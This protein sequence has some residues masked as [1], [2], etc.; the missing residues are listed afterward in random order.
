[1]FQSDLDLNAL[2]LRIAQKWQEL[3]GEPLIPG[4]LEMVYREVLVLIASWSKIDTERAIALAFDKYLKEIYLL[5]YGAGNRDAAIALAKAFTDVADVNIPPTTNPMA[6]QV[7]LLAKVGTPTAGQIAALQTYLNSPK[8][9]NTCDT[10][11]VAAAS[12]LLWNFNAIISVMGDPIAL[13][14]LATSAI[15]NYAAQQLKLGA[16]I[17]PS[18]LTTILRNISGI[19]DV[20]L[21]S[22]IA[23]IV[24]NA[25]QFPKLGTLTINTAIV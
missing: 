15:S 9:K 23:N 20:N 12:E 13:K 4:S 3:S 1:M 10:Y 6:I 17:R 21:S 5:P 19:V 25:S 7:F 24:T 16:T 14:T 11:V 18:D 2:R 22:P 8:V